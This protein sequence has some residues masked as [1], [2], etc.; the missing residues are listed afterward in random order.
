MAP[1]GPQDGS[2]MVLASISSNSVRR[3]W[4]RVS[5]RPSWRLLRA[6]RE[7]P[8]GPERAQEGPK[9]ALR[10]LQEGPKMA[11]RWSLQ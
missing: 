7:L 10:W 4:T 5:L 6:L 1:R 9:M 3:S 11:P 8:Q 2:K